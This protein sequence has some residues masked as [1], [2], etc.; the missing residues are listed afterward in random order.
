MVYL[1]AL[2]IGAFAW[3][4]LGVWIG[5]ASGI[6]FLILS[7]I[8]QWGYYIFAVPRL[9]GNDSVDGL[10]RNL[11][12]IRIGLYILFIGTIAY[13]GSETGRI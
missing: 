11:K 12:L 1:A 8:G 4:I 10:L 2:S 7:A 3:Q 6:G 9:E 13:I 5:I